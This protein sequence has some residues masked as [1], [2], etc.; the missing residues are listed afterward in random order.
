MNIEKIDIEL[1]SRL[2]NAAGAPGYEDR[3]REQIKQEIKDYIDEMNVDNLGNLIALKKGTNHDASNN[4]NKKVMVD[5][6]MD[7]IAFM[8]T[9][10]DNEGFVRFHPLGGF[11]PKTL[12]AQRVVIHGKKDMLGILGTKA[13]HMMNAEERKKAAELDDYFVD[14]GLPKEEVEKFVSIGDTITRERDLVEIG[15]TISTKSLD[16]R[17]AVYILVETLK[18]IE[19]TPYDFYA[20]FSV[21]EEVGLRGALVATRNINPDFAICLD[22]TV[23]NDMPGVSAQKRVTELGKGAGIKIIDSQTICDPRMVDFLKA[24]ADRESLKWQ[25][26]VLPA[27]GTNTASLQRGGSG[28]IAG[29]I[30]IPTRYLHQVTEM[31]HKDDVLATTRLLMAALETMDKYNWDR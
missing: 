12:T 16:N 23:T 15:N 27:G 26:E 25:A 11:D 7:E 24:T 1:L 18:K 13:I 14:L 21:Q 4:N 2:T 9:H 30:S 5:A 3:I 8:V 10:I 22:T 29:A 6:H 19:A 20:V 28:S 17:I 31:V